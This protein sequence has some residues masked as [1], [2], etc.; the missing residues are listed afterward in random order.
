MKSRF[1]SR[2]SRSS[3]LARA[4]RR[5]LI[6]G[7][8]RLERRDLFALTFQFNFNTGGTIGFNTPD[9]QL[10]T[11]RREALQ[12]AATEFGS[13]FN[14][15]A[16]ITVDVF[17]ANTGQ[18]H[19][20]GEGAFATNSPDS[21]FDRRVPQSK[22]LE[23]GIDR[24]AAAAD[25]FLAVNWEDNNPT[26][27]FVWEYGDDV[28][29]PTEVDFKTAMIHELTHIMGFLSGIKQDGGDTFDPPTPAGQA[30]LWDV[31]DQFVSDSTGRLINAT[32]HQLD[33][34]RWN[35]ASVGGT[36]N[37]TGL[38]FDGPNA[39]AATAV[40]RFRCIHLRR[41]NQGAASVICASSI[42]MSPMRRMS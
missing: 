34:T 37:T 33:G 42:L 40:I 27:G 5:K 21:G 20:K 29:S 18:L 36:T 2:S 10:Q 23:N 17:N 38:F 1:A 31:F 9:Q 35:T 16:T 41:L 30:G 14:H 4:R 8:E 26:A 13:W 28:E 25:G 32:S 19:A 24:N 12:A 6:A 15:T 22:V 3:S 7:L 39:K 11:L